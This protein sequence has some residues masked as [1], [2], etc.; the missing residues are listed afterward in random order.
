M[1]ADPNTMTTYRL[2]NGG[3]IAGEF[4]FVTEVDWFDADDDPT[5]LIQE[6]WVVQSRRTMVAP[7]VPHGRSC[8]FEVPDTNGGWCDAEATR[9]VSV[10][11]G[12]HLEPRCDKH[13][14]SS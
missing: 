1:S 8:V 2:V 6:V 12:D 3:L 11:D 5:E 4:S 13:G 9:W 10:D 14:G 7:A